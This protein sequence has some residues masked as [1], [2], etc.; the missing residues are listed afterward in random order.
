MPVTLLSI[1]KKEQSS[2][3][4][5][6]EGRKSL[7]IEDIKIETRIEKDNNGKE[8]EKTYFTAY[9][10]T[11][12]KSDAYGDIPKGD[13]VYDFEIFKDNPIMLV[14]HFNSVGSIA[15]TWVEFEENAKGLKVIGLFMNDPQTDIV[16]HAIAAYKQGHG[17]ALSIGG[18][19]L[20]EDKNNPNYITKAIIY[21][22]SLVG[23]GADPR[24]LAVGDKPKKLPIKGEGNIPETLRAAVA[25]YRANPSKENLK[26]IQKLKERR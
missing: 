26:T 12:N 2:V 19:W 23:V 7:D 8:I 17:R 6:F 5:Y 16:K 4:L 15:G 25:D 3:G 11:K 10:N 24:A 9:A 18:K 14:D 1:E 20:Y 22:I 13:E 21:E